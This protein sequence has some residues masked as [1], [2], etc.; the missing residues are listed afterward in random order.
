MS[1][2][3]KKMVI[4]VPVIKLTVV[5]INIYWFTFLMN[6]L[7]FFKVFFRVSEIVFN[8]SNKV[9]ASSNMKMTIRRIRK[10]FVSMFPICVNPDE[11]N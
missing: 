10:D 4:M 1:R 9:V 7:A 11:I 6:F 3:V 5:L 8:L 2:Y